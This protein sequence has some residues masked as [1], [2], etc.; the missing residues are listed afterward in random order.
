MILLPIANI[1]RD[2]EIIQHQVVANQLNKDQ[3]AD[4]I[5]RNYLST[6]VNWCYARG[7]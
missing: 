5:P 4:T 2:F 6:R 7:E 1:S 3:I